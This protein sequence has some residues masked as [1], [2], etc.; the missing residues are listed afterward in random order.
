[1]AFKE[2]ILDTQTIVLAG[3]G[4]FLESFGTGNIV[5]DKEEHLFGTGLSTPVGDAGERFVKPG[6]GRW[7]GGFLRFN[8]TFYL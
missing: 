5:T 6:H 3:L 1:M 8:A 2:G 4:D 7:R